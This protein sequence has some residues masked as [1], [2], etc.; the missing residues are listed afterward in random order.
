MF[1]LINIIVVVVVVVV[2]VEVVVV[3]VECV[4]VQCKNYALEEIFNELCISEYYWNLS[5]IQV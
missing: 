5:S 4:V 2:A 3:G 1:T